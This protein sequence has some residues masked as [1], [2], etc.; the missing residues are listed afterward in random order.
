MEGR[1]VRLGL[2][3]GDKGGESGDVDETKPPGELR[4]SG[5]KGVGVTGEGRYDG[6]SKGGSGLDLVDFQGAP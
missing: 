1:R 6:G 3:I 2:I 5:K 4:G